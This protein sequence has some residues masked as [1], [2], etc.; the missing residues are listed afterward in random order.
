MSGGGAPGLHA[1]RGTTHGDGGLGQ[2]LLGLGDG[3]LE[4]LA[5]GNG[6]DALL[7]QLA[8]RVEQGAGDDND[9][10]GAVAGGHVLRLG[11]LDQHARGRV[12][13]LQDRG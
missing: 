3:Q 8:A 7:Q 9:C 5:D 11:Q 4:R 13:D 1:G 10:G 12:Q 2:D 6:V